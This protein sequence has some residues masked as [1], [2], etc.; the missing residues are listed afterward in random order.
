MLFL[1]YH[2]ECQMCRYRQILKLG[3]AQQVFDVL[4]WYKYMGAV[5]KWAKDPLLL[6]FLLV[7]CFDMLLA[8]RTII[9]FL[10]PVVH[11]KKNTM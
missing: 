10:V 8:F 7:S 4:Y 11:V 9:L 2:E 5:N 1:W 3:H 6:L